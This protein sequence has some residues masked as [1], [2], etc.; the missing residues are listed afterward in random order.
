MATS[1]K[2]GKIGRLVLVRHGESIWNV[3]DTARNLVTRF[4]GWIDVPLTERGRMQARAAGKC[5]RL[6]GVKPDAVFT[7]LLKRANVIYT[8]TMAIILLHSCNYPNR[9]PSLDPKS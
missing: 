3:T 4:T 9:K 6:F 2:A 5:L 1:A 7:S 8:L